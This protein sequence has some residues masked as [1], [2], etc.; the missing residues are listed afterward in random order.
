[1]I[2]RADEAEI[3][4]FQADRISQTDTLRLWWQQGFASAGTRPGWLYKDSHRKEVNK[5][6]I[7]ECSW[8]LPQ[9]VWPLRRM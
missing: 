8:L 3:N 6:F 1:L 5:C 4:L 2:K 9:P 7:E